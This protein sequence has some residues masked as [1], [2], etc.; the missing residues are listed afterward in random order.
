MLYR[1]KAVTQDSGEERTG[2]I[3]A[4]SAEV[5]IGSLQRRKFVVVSIVSVD[6]VPF[7]E[8]VAVFEKKI[9]Y[10]DIVMLS[11]QI[12]TLF[13]AQV[14]VLRLFQVL[15][16]Q[17]ENPTLKRAL[18]DVTE[19]IQAGTSLSSALGKHPEIFSDFY[20]NMVRAG[21]ES[22]N[23]ADTFEYLANY[24]DRSY[25]LVAKT[26]NALIY[27]AF[28]ITVFIVVM[29]L[30][31]VMVIPKLSAILLEAGGELP[32]YTKFVIALS[33]FAVE[34]GIYAFI[35]ITTL[36][37]FAWRW[38]RTKDGKTIIG[39]IQMEIPYI[40]DLYRKLY[41]ARIADNLHTMISSGISMTRAVEIAAAT[42]GSDIYKAILDQASDD[43][44]GGVPLSTALGKHP[45]IP[46]IMV[47]MVKVGE[48]SAEVANILETLAKF[49][50]REVDSAVD[51][52]VSMIEPAMIV[53]LGVG[54]GGLLTSVLIPIYNV[55]NAM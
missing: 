15:V 9:K 24:M 55:T 52:L 19:D 54:V 38:A 36:V 12:A 20:I 42:V 31:L 29:V 28:V 25:A 8:R 44:R 30:M 51:T 18:N 14:S 13:H 6:D 32:V 46:Q 43:I 11:R 35:G 48:E 21:E 5:A 4:S 3:E 37:I 49:Y 2:T 34:Y 16:V 10:R 39:R 40:G 7:W 17:V 33:N 26:K 23:L 27:P 41:L 47:Q 50:T 53:M 22:G 1:Y 45:D